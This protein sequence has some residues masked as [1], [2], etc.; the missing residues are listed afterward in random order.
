MYWTI[1]CLA[2]CLAV[3]LANGVSTSAAGKPH[4]LWADPDEIAVTMGKPFL[5]TKSD[6]EMQWFPSL[7]QISEK[8]LLLS[9]SSSP[10]AI[11][12][13]GAR[14]GYV[15]TENGGRTWSKPMYQPR[16]VSSWIHRKDGTCLWF[17]YTLDYVSESTATFA[18]GKSTDGVHYDWS[19]TATVDV[20]PNK[21]NSQLD[22]TKGVASFVFCRS[23]LEMPDGAMLATMYGRFLGDVLDRS[24]LVRSTDGGAT[25][26]Y[27][28]TIGYD[29]TVGHEG[30]NEP[31]VAQ[32]PNGNLFAVMRN[33]AWVPMWSSR[34]TD[35]GKTWSKI[36]RM[37]AR[38]TMAAVFPD[39]CLMSNGMLACSA[40]RRG[41]HLM[42]A[43]D[44][45][46]D[47]WTDNT[48][49]VFDTPSIYDS[50]STFYTGI[51]EVAPG[52]LLYVYDVRD[53]NDIRTGKDI[54]PGRF[55][56]IYGVFIDVKKQ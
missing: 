34:S 2:L 3:G 16:A 1:C 11:N 28:S 9:F 32:L 43:P 44:P 19:T 6:K 31:C 56:K 40:G 7:M 13:G 27:L 12:P 51:R 24:I 41:A 25:W 55:W 10:D 46:K 23:V 48:L 29:P 52:R 42:F 53:G 5:I 38:T 22:G 49:V 33:W 14:M 18:L 35:G 45:Y 20:S 30:L 4:I 8:K 17:N 39:L 15:V 50:P 54:E 26:K 21:F 37:P 47:N 36:L